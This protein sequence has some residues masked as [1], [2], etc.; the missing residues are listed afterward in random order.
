MASIEP[1]EIEFVMRENITQQ[2][3]QVDAALENTASTAATAATEIQQRIEQQKQTIQQ[4]TAMLDEVD[5]RAKKTGNSGNKAQIDAVLQQ[6]QQLRDTFEQQSQTINGVAADTAQLSE[7]TEQ[8][9]ARE[10]EVTQIMLGLANAGQKN[11]TVYQ[12]LAQEQ[13]LIQDSLGGV[14]MAAKG[15]GVAIGS[16]GNNLSPVQQALQERIAQEKVSIEQ[17]KTDIA[18]MNMQLKKAGPAQKP[19]IT[20]DITAANQALIEEKNILISLEGQVDKTATSHASLR[21]QLMNIRN[22]MGRMLLAGQ[23]DTDMYRQKEAELQRLGIA[24]RKMQNLQSSL[25]TGGS[26]A[27]AYGEGVMAMSGSMMAA[28]GVMSMFISKNEELT[29]VQQHLNDAMNVTMGLSMTMMTLQQTSTFRILIVSK[30]TQAW[31]AAQKMLNTQLGISAELSKVL[32]FSGIGLVAAG[33][34]ALILLLQKQKAAD[35]EMQKQLE[36]SSEAM[37]ER[38]AIDE[39]YGKS[40]AESFT[41][42]KKLQESWSETGSSLEKQKEFIKDN[43]SE[44]TKLGIAVNDTTDADNVFVRNSDAVIEALTARAMAAAGMS[45]AQKKFEDY[46]TKTETATELNTVN[47]KSSSFGGFKEPTLKGDV[48][49]TFLPQLGSALS[50]NLKSL[51]QTSYNQ[52][53]SLLKI[54]Q[55]ESK[56][57]ADILKKAGIS[58]SATPDKAVKPAN[59]QNNEDAL[60]KNEVTYQQKID[61]ARIAAMQE[62]AAKRKAEAEKEYKDE[63]DYISLQKVQVSKLL[64]DAEK[65]KDPK[66]RAQAQTTANKSNADLDTLNLQAQDTYEAKVKMIDET[67]KE[68]IAAIFEDVD[69]KFQSELDRN[70]ASIDRYYKEQIK[71]AQEAGASV[72]QINTLGTDWNNERGMAKSDNTSKQLDFKEQIELGTQEIKNQSIPFESTRQEK[73]LQIQ[74]SY[75]EKQRELLK[76]E[77]Q[78]QDTQ[79]KLAQNSLD[80]AKNNQDQK[81]LPAKRLQET[82]TAAAQLSSIFKDINDRAALFIGYISQMASGIAQIASGDPIGGAISLATSLVSDIVSADADAEKKEIENITTLFQ[83]LNLQIDNS[84]KKISELSGSEAMSQIKASFVEITSSIYQTSQALNSFLLNSRVLGQSQLQIMSQLGT[85]ELATKMPQSITGLK[86]DL[87]DIQNAIDSIITRL[88]E[89]GLSSAETS[90]LNDTLTQLQTEQSDLTQLLDQYTQELTGTTSDSIVNSIADA[91]ANS[92]SSITDF[93]NTFQSLMQNAVIAS[94]KT[95]ALEGPLQNWYNTFAQMSENGLTQDDI[96][97]L[98]AMYNSIIANAQTM[99]TNLQDITGVQFAASTDTNTLTGSVSGM[100]EDTGT[101][102]EGDVTALR[103]NVATLLLNDT[104]ALTLMQKSLDTQIEIA[105]NTANTADT[106]KTIDWRMS[107]WDLNGIKVK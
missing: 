30:A 21:Q 98:Q 49:T 73:I 7:V 57:F 82:A 74:R 50:T 72:S 85:L 55:D 39:D 8:L 86:S 77:P 100:S 3:K 94:L 15:A 37:K 13:H 16:M 6:S 83:E 48:N 38:Q 45:A 46:F 36:K 91:F 27:H 95:Q 14:S 25:I 70:L 63:L 90:A 4:A 17:I 75:L 12:Q 31:A 106:L 54:S 69:S 104:N 102:L 32:M 99:F 33:I 5:A 56:K 43:A 20:S 107:N 10:R 96:T 101:A 44:F 42:Y 23:E 76:K 93:A 87:T 59:E 61:A 81:D 88:G 9:A 105:T 18:E 53:V 84:I 92:K 67:S 51:A 40:M 52:G 47:K 65:D 19:M 103:L 28:Q 11:S 2:T 71:K 41:T 29:V 35:E 64:K 80:L 89:K 66:K 58:Q 68:A 97:Q 78:T 79:N 62:G 24:Y 60:A 22:E 34:A 26:T 1:V